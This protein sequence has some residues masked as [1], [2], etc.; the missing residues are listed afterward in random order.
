MNNDRL[1]R[2]LP[3]LLLIAA[4]GCSR[5]SDEATETS[6][7]APDTTAAPAAAAA[8][9]SQPAEAAGSEPVDAASS[10][11]A[12]TAAATETAAAELARQSATKPITPRSASPAGARV[13][14]VTPQNGA[15][16]SSPFPVEFSVSGM[17]LARAGENLPNTGHHHLLIDTDLPNPGQ[18]IPADSQ[19]VHF[20]DASSSTMLKLEPGEHT[21]QLLFAD[22]L[23][24]PHNPPVYSDR[25]NILVE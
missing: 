2:C 5:G 3:L 23:H 4:A 9:N 14:F 17:E 10:A 11:P 24:I 13:S 19:H 20:G 7:A 15:V 12:E 22:Y 6:A 21:L 1:L 16:V 18:P 8:A 25:I